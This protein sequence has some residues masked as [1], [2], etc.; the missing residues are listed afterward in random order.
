MARDRQ[1][2]LRD[3]RRD[4]GTISG[5]GTARE[6]KGNSSWRDKET[7][8]GPEEQF[9]KYLERP[10]DSPCMWKIIRGAAKEPEQ[11]G[12]RPQQKGPRDSL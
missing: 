8:S 1:K 7:V 2:Y 12:M 5:E 10:Q 4:K 11:Q 9:S 6:T 3:S